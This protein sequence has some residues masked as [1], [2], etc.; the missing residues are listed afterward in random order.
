ME[1]ETNELINPLL[2]QIEKECDEL[3]EFI[4]TGDFPYHKRCYYNRVVE[5]ASAMLLLAGE[6]KGIDMLRDHTI[7]GGE[8]T[9]T[10]EQLIS[11]LRNCKLNI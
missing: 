8:F 1:I 3:K 11:G 6:I 5:H 4:K 9:P 7:T 2:E 10:K